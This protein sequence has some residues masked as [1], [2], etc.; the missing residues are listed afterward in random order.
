VSTAEAQSKEK[1]VKAKTVNAFFDVNKMSD[2]SD[3][4]PAKPV[5]P[6]G[7][8][9]KIAVVMPFSGPAALNGQLAFGWAQ[10][11]A[12]DINK[13]GGIWVDGKKKLVQL[14]KA[15]HQSKPDVCK[16]VCERMA[17]QEKVHVIFG[18]AGSNLMK[19]MMEVG[20]KHKIIV[21]NF[22]ALSDDLMD[23]TSFNR[24]TFMTTYDTWSIGRGLAYYFGQIR[25]KEKKFYLLSQDYSFGHAMSEA[26]RQGLKDYYPEA[27]IVGDDYHKLFLTDFAPYLEKIK[28]SGAEAIF[29]SDWIPD[30]GNLLKQARQAGLNIPVAD[31][32]LDDATPLSELGVEGSKGLI[33]LTQY[34][35][36][37]PILK[38]PEQVKFH[39]AWNNQWKK[40]NTSPYNAKLM[41]YA[42]GQNGAY[43]MQLYWLMSVIERAK[44]TDP[45]KIIK[46]WENDSYRI[47]SGKVWRMRP[48]DHK[49]IQDL[50]V[51]EYVPPEEQKISMNIPPY[52]W[53]DECSYTGNLHIVPAEKVLPWM[54]PKLDRCKG[55]DGWG[56]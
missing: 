30:L 13:R 45:E 12:H 25:K 29:T 19:V 27:E 56:E 1:A 16:R 39:K 26:F 18:T 50:A 46:V 7:D 35:F 5:I 47:L 37:S 22:A 55:K 17:L 52:R 38:T 3:Y 2:M 11:V 48:C 33:N 51:T 34:E 14:I 28:G 23:A 24:Y 31:R 41:A 6:T 53:F 10:W 9:I 40:W 44:S 54:D 4:N 20:A 15:D 42:E 43:L 8:T 49:L 32:V 21:H 36:D